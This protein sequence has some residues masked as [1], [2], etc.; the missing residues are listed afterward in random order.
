[1]RAG[2]RDAW[3]RCDYAEVVGV[4]RRWPARVQQAFVATP[5]KALLDL[6]YL[7]PEGDTPTYLQELRLQNMAQLD[8]DGGALFSSCFLGSWQ[9]LP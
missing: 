3:R 5:E 6:V 4:A 1:M 9:S 7:A 2:F 8:P